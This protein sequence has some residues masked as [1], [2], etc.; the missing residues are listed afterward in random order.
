[1][2]TKGGSKKEH[3]YVWMTCGMFLCA[4]MRDDWDAKSAGA[5]ICVVFVSDRDDGASKNKSGCCR[6]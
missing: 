4:R 2:R 3:V 5:S 6:D 1:M